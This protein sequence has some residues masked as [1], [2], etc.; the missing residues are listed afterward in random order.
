MKVNNKVIVV[1][2]GGSG[3]GRELVFELLKRGARVAA[4]DISA[5]GLAETL[6]L[7]GEARDRV[8]T[9]VV[10]IADRAAVEALPAAVIAAHSAVDGVINNAG[11]IQKFVRVKDLP[12]ADVERVLNVNFYGTL[13]MVAAFLPHLLARPEAHILN[14]A[15]MGAFVPVPGQTIYGA[16]KAAVKLFTE[17]LHSELMGTRVGVTLA[18]PGA[19]T[20]NI[21]LNSGVMTRDL[22]EKADKEYKTTPADVVAREFVNGMEAGKYRVLVGSDTKTMD[23]LHRLMPKRAASIIYNQMKNLLPK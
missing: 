6:K 15:S 16:S 11:I 5:E 12:M 23:F 1:T 4:V 2:G 13:H 22:Q 17:G 18:I 7:A 3:I 9:H 10:N 14:V 19:T 8:S 20:T 21:A